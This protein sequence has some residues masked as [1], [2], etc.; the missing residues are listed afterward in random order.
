MT[1]SLID[2]LKLFTFFSLVWQPVFPQSALVGPRTTAVKRAPWWKNIGKH[3]RLRY[4]GD[5]HSC[6]R[7]GVSSIF[8]SPT[9][10]RLGIVQALVEVRPLLRNGSQ[11]WSSSRPRCSPSSFSGPPPCRRATCRFPSARSLQCSWSAVEYFSS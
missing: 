1:L 7:E 4:L 10:L 2:L 5:N 6:F 9:I 8:A 3:V 11:P